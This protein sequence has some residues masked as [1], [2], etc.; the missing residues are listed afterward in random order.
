MAIRM[1]SLKADGPDI[2]NSELIN[3]YYSGKKTPNKKEAIIFTRRSLS[4]S[5]KAWVGIAIIVSI[6]AGSVVT[7]YLLKKVGS[8][9]NLSHKGTLISSTKNRTLYYYDYEEIKKR[10][11]PF[12]LNAEKEG[13]AINFNKLKD[14]NTAMVSFAAKG[15]IGGETIAIILK[16]AFNKSNANRDD[17]ILTPSLAANG[18]R[19]FNIKFDNLSLPL[20]KTRISQVRFDTSSN[21]TKNN[22][23]AAV[24]IKDIKIE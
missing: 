14:M 7:A 21:L 1:R 13:I 17:V 6:S 22:S 12:L 23:D 11:E 4:L 16:D 24:Y 3:T 5:E 2:R 19:S 20:D 10:P 18:W 8:V 15:N 9:E